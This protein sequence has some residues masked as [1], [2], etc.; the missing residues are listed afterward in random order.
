MPVPRLSIIVPCYNEAENLPE[1]VARLEA[2]YEQL[3]VAAETL[4][5][6]D[7]S[8]DATLAVARRLAEWHPSVV[9]LHH[10]T[11]RGLFA[12][13]QTGLSHAQGDY[14][15]VIDADLQYQPEDITRLWAE[16]QATPCDVVQGVRW[17]VAERSGLR[18]WLSRGFNLLLNLTFGMKLAD[19]KSGFFLA[20]REVVR[21]ILHYRC[22]YRYPQ[23]FVM[24]SAHAR[25]FSIGQVRT[26]FSARARGKS[27]LGNVPWRAVAWSFV[28]LARA[29]GEFGG[30]A[31]AGE[32]LA[33]FLQSRRPP[34]PPP[35]PAP[36][37]RRLA[38]Y[39]R[40][41]PVHHW[42]LSRDAG[43]Y[44]EQLEASQWL[45]PAQLAEYQRERLRALVAHAARHVPFYRHRL[46]EA[47]IR[48]ER[49]ESLADLAALP[50]LTKDEIRRHAHTDLW[51]DNVRR[52]DLYPI[53]TSGS[54]GEPLLAYVDRQ[55]LE[56]RWAATLRSQEWAGYRFGDRHAR[57]WHQTIGMTRGQIGKER[58]D[59]W[60]TRRLF[61]PAWEMTTANLRQ[62]VKRMAAWRPALIDGYAESLDLLARFLADEPRA[63]PGLAGLI[64]SA[65][66]LSDASRRRIEAA[67]GARVFDKYGARE[68]S[69]I[70]YQCEHGPGYHVVGENYLVE[71][72]VGDRPA[73]PGEIGEVLITDLNNRALPFLRYRIGD[74]AQAADDAPCPCGRG[75]P[76]IAAIHGRTQAVV[77]GAEGQLVPGS[78]FAHLLKEY[79]YAIRQFQVVQ[80]A[81]GKIELRLVRGGRFSPAVL[82]EIVGQLRRALGAKLRVEPVF[83]PAIPLGPNGKHQHSVSRVRYD[84]AAG[85]VVR[86]PEGPAANEWAPGS[87]S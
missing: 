35:R 20:R 86:V 15:G 75:L 18:L 4:L 3:G 50:P 17:N 43:R 23:S 47:G 57:L 67:F 40:A 28:D 38:R 64:S 34:V 21:E 12:G 25:G 82:D 16:L 68:F 53:R 62:V 32:A 63:F 51:A 78:F 81:P 44:L 49:V 72:M 79:D 42:V 56:W 7:A 77:M 13:W 10:E 22:R 85:Q 84:F 69:G 9:A 45:T 80:D 39:L 70:A 61:V 74:L 36:E 2:T 41:M 24:V 65:Q 66:T 48:P 37:A 83:L 30:R 31:P 8:R 46:D 87:V 58:L 27:F 1:L 26:V 11:N 55:Q 29:R 14:L 54:T 76:R 6:D 52:E 19:N 71:I 5:V 33:E 73:R 60:W 59:S